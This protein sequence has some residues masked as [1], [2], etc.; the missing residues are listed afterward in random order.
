MRFVAVGVVCASGCA[1]E[2]DPASVG[3]AD[4]SQLLQDACKPQPWP[5]DEEGHQL[6]RVT[7]LTPDG[8][9]TKWWAPA[10]PA[11][12]VF[13][14][15]ANKK[16]ASTMFSVEHE[17]LY[18]EF[19]ERDLAYAAVS[20][21]GGKWDLKVDP[22]NG[23]FARVAEVRNHLIQEGAIAAETPVFA[24]GFSGGSMFAPV[25]I[26]LGMDAGWDVRAFSSHNTAPKIAPE[27]VAAMFTA[28]Q[29]DNP[30]KIIDQYEEQALLGMPTMLVELEELALNPL[31]FTKLSFVTEEESFAYFDELLTA[32]LIDENGVKMAD[33][34]ELDGALGE[35]RDIPAPAKSQLTVI[36][37]EHIFSADAACSE[38][39]FLVG[40][41]PR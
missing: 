30:V 21:S 38:A 29:N 34:A 31:R 12:I 40:Q 41:L 7:E 28:H 39:E 16:T 37:R 4:V 22:D 19:A 5:I 35:L 36:W 32:G 6:D 26:Q 27:G 1:L 8:S 3:G 11:G 33:G 17:E 25:L 15:H 14:L 13:M 23:D 24:V 9:V 20:N 2:V 10:D 18:N